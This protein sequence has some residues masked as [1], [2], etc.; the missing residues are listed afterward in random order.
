M[1]VKKASDIT[2]ERWCVRFGIA[3]VAVCFDASA[4]MRTFAVIS[5]RTLCPKSSKKIPVSFLVAEGRNQGARWQVSLCVA[6]FRCDVRFPA[7]VEQ[8]SCFRCL[9]S[10]GIRVSVSTRRCPCVRRERQETVRLT[11]IHSYLSECTDNRC[12]GSQRKE[13]ARANAHS[14]LLRVYCAAL[15]TRCT[16]R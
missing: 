8:E 3:R 7:A 16:F 10:A 15:L 14:Y 13:R 9:Q 1:S 2:S 11:L 6:G 5:T 12:I 4:P